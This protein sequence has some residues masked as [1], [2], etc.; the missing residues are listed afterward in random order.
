MYA[1]PSSWF[2]CFGHGKRKGYVLKMVMVRATD[3]G[4]CSVLCSGCLHCMILPWKGGNICA[5]AQGCRQTIQCPPSRQIQAVAMMGFGSDPPSPFHRRKAGHTVG[6]YS[7]SL[8]L[9]QVSR[10]KGDAW[11]CQND[12]R[13]KPTSLSWWFSEAKRRRK[14][15]NE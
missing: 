13:L 3:S 12:F 4:R 2:P 9:Q 1:R 10:P 5:Y 6:N 15:L 11:I 14:T 7:C 8:S